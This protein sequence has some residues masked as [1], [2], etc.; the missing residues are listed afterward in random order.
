MRKL[1]KF[2]KKE[3]AFYSLVFLS[4]QV[5]QP[6]WVYDNFW[7]KAN[8]YESIAFTVYYWQFALVYSI[9]LVPVVWYV[10]RLVKRYL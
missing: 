4:G 9:I 1:P 8:F 6:N 10:V 7:G 2:T 5:Y 3:V